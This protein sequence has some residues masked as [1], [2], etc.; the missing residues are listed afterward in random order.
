[1]A[2]WASL[3]PDHHHSQI[4]P[5]AEVRS[6]ESLG[7]PKWPEIDPKN[8]V[9][10]LRNKVSRNVGDIIHVADKG[11]ITK[12]TAEKTGE[13]RIEQKKKEFLVKLYPILKT[14]SVTLKK[15]IENHT[16]Q[17]FDVPGRDLYAVSLNGKN[18]DFL[19]EKSGKIF[20]NLQGRRSDPFRYAA[21][22]GISDGE[23]EEKLNNQTY[24]LVKNWK[25][26]N[27]FSNEWLIEYAKWGDYIHQMVVEME[28]LEKMKW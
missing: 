13:I 20:F 23:F 10:I 27:S 3:P 14:D 17:L 18:V 5:P 9:L 12:T 4:Q 11:V 15:A 2:L 26:L 1:M 8:P 24:F 21:L 22:R 16:V 28:K 6:A 19:Y 7:V 25:T